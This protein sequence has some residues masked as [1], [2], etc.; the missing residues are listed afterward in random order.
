MFFKSKSWGFV[1]VKIV[2]KLR[3]VKRGWHLVVVKKRI[4]IARALYGNPEILVL[5]EAT[6]ALDDRTESKI[7]EEIYKVSEDLTLIII[8]HRLSTIKQCEIIYKLDNG[9]LVKTD[10]DSLITKKNL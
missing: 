8:A 5:D 1:K 6:S 9:K 7:M 4:A 2:L 3:L 10:F